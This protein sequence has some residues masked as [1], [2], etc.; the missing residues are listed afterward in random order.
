[1]NYD[2]IHRVLEY[3][4]N[5]EDGLTESE[6]IG[7]LQAYI[8]ENPQYGESLRTELSQALDDQSFSWRE[9]LE[10]HQVEYFD[11]ETAARDFARK[12]VL[13]AIFP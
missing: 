2:R 1:M 5:S 4:F 11:D 6:S 3:Y 10:K 13:M 8:R 12:Y 7:R 9:T